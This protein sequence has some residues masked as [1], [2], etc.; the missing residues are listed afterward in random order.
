MHTDPHTPDLRPD[1][2]AHAHARPHAGPEADDER[3]YGVEPEFVEEIVGL[4]RAREREAVL[5]RLDGLHAADI[6]DLIEQA[7]PAERADLIDLLPAA[8]DGEVLSYLNPDLRE[9]LIERF[10]PQE[11]AAAVEE[12]ASLADELQNAG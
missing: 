4:L 7:E 11:L 5:A 1:G 6:A 2:A 8:L 10:E 9:A 12:I 3:P